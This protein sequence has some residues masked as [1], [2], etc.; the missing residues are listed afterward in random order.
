M[1]TTT[2][3]NLLY[4]EEGQGLTEYALILILVSIASVGV[5]TAIGQDI[6]NLFSQVIP[7]P[8]GS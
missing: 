5:L 3:M 8:S 6:V 1:L 7:L 4:D 2:I